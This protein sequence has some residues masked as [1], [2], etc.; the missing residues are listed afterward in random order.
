VSSQNPR[1]RVG[2]RGHWNW[3]LA[4]GGHR[5]LETIEFQLYSDR[6]LAGEIR[7]GLGPY[8]VLNLIA[9][10]GSPT[11]ARESLLLRVDRHFEVDVPLHI[12]DTEEEGYHGGDLSDEVAA[13]LSLALGWRIWAGG[14]VRTFRADDD[15]RGRP[16]AEWH[17]NRPP[18]LAPVRGTHRAPG[19][20]NLN[21]SGAKELLATY[22]AVP[23]SKALALVR[24]A[25][26]YQRSIWEVDSSP[27]TAWIRMVSAIETAAGSWFE[28][29]MPSPFAMLEAS[30]PAVAGTLKKYGNEKVQRKVAERLS[31]IS[32]A[33]HKFRSF[34]REFLPP[35]PEARPSEHFQVPWNA[36]E[37]VGR[38]MRIYHYRSRSLHAGTPFPM[39]LCVPPRVV[40]QSGVLEECPSG[41]AAAG[42]DGMWLAEDMVM[43]FHTFEYIA[44]QALVAW[45]A[46]LTSVPAE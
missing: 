4:M 7:T 12:D 32:G 46:D 38:L 15:P 2:P 45:W 22:P 17:Q 5:A 8:Q 43:H 31:K 21:I 29:E 23:S 18:H 25:R 44:R 11:R 39:P 28:E 40:D 10:Q 24:A 1:K 13:L 9:D 34:L 33:T 19:P 3:G 6:G 20:L 14:A 36:K 37:L 41:I 30:M 16:R 35:P 26:L 27:E 42:A